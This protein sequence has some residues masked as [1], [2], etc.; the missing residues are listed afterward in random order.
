[1][2]KDIT[3]FSIWYLLIFGYKKLDEYLG[4]RQYEFEK[5]KLLTRLQRE[6]L[7]NRWVIILLWAQNFLFH[8]P[9]LASFHSKFL[10][11]SSIGDLS[12]INFSCINNFSILYLLFIRSNLVLFSWFIELSDLH[13][14]DF[15][16][17]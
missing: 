16:I 8:S 15:D 10:A 6:N 9:S 11:R 3:T 14:C 17:Y 1:M 5:H 12:T 7:Q 2:R 13:Q 4:L